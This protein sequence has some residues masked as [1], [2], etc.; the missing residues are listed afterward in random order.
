MAKIICRFYPNYTNIP[1]DVICQYLGEAFCCHDW[2]IENGVRADV[3][4]QDVE[5]TIVDA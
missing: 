5:E 4:K 2:F 1:K 3:V